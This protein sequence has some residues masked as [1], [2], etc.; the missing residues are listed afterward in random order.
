M[1]QEIATKAD[2]RLRGTNLKKRSCTICATDFETSHSHKKYCS[3]ICANKANEKSKQT[4]YEKNKTQN[5]LSAARWAKENPEKV[6]EAKQKY[7]E[8]TRDKAKEYREATK[9][10]RA[11][12]KKQNRHKFIAYQAKRRIKTKEIYSEFDSFVAEEAYI[13]SSLRKQ[14][15]VLWHVDH[16]LPISLGGKHFAENLQVI[17]ALLNLKKGAKH[18]SKYIWS[19]FFK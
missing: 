9:D 12:Y 17:P 10:T 11:E 15:G 7:A 2:P 13:L 16:I 14:T 19:D 4:F 5:L 6:R 18:T 8:K 1:K 3:P